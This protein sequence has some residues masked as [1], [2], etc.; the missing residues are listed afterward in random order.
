MV[1]LIAQPQQAQRSFW[2]AKAFHGQG[3][4]AQTQNDPLA[5]LATDV[6][7]AILARPQPPKAHLA[8]DEST[9]VQ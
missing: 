1:Q 3:L 5:K 4:M 6:F 9:L 8:D 7:A 2:T